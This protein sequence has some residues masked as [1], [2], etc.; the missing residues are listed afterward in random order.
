MCIT[1]LMK[2]EIRRIQVDLIMTNNF[3]SILYRIT[4][5]CDSFHFEGVSECLSKSFPDFFYIL[6]QNSFL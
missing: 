3:F 2:H 1:I 5:D 6:Q 4:M